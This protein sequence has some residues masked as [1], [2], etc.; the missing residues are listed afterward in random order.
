[1]QILHENPSLSSP[2]GLIVVGNKGRFLCFLADA[3][4][5][6]AVDKAVSAYKNSVYASPTYEIFRLEFKDWF[7]SNEVYLLSDLN[8]AYAIQG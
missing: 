2:R 5:I 8:H 3:A 4:D 1:M 7:L 6:Q